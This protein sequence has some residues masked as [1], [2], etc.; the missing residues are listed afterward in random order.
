MRTE[1]IELEERGVEYVPFDKYRIQN[2][3]T[4][5]KPDRITTSNLF[6]WLNLKNSV[7]FRLWTR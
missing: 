4:Q 6:S 5:V 7:R 1:T 3:P 2:D